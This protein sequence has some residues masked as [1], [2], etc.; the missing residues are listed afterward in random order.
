M[1]VTELLTEIVAPVASR[2]PSKKT[3]GVPLCSIT[4]SAPLAL[5]NKNSPLELVDAIIS[6]IDELLIA[7]IVS[8]SLVTLEKFIAIPLIFIFEEAE[9]ASSKF[10]LTVTILLPEAVTFVDEETLLMA[11]AFAAAEADL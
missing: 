11:I 5:V 9:E 1:K 10:R 2:C 4:M 3:P 6:P 8:A 7:V